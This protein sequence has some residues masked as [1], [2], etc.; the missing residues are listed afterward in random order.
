MVIIMYEMTM[1]RIKVIREMLASG[2]R[3]WIEL[4]DNIVYEVVFAKGIIFE[5]KHR[6]VFTVLYIGEK[7]YNCWV[8]ERGV[9]ISIAHKRKEGQ[10]P[11]SFI[12]LT[13]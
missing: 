8:S 5:V 7:Y 2:K 3:V 13:L 6:G 11:L 10:A 4:S 1:N 9:E 12:K